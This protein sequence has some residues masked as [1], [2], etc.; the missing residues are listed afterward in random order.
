MIS[1]NQFFSH[2]LS[3]FSRKETRKIR[4]IRV[5]PLQ[6]YLPGHLSELKSEGQENHFAALRKS[7]V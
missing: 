1:D 2:G 6:K 7:A 3:G 4:E 5:N